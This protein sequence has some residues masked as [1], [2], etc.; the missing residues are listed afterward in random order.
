[1]RCYYCDEEVGAPGAL[2][3]CR[4]T[5]TQ[6]IVDPGGIARRMVTLS[7]RPAVLFRSEKIVVTH[8]KDSPLVD[9]SRGEKIVDSELV[10][11]LVDVFCGKKIVDFGNGIKWRTRG[12]AV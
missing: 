1:M 6:F 12:D 11:E 10:S 8:D 7:C 2:H 3:E 5:G 4:G 9:V